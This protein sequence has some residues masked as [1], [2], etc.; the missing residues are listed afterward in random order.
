MRTTTAAQPGSL[1]YAEA[2]RREVQAFGTPDQIAPSCQQ[3]LTLR[4]IRRTTCTVAL[5]V[6]ILIAGWHLI[7]V[8][9]P[10][11]GYPCHRC[12]DS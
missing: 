8:A 1:S 3:E 4:Q 11:Q 2:A 6:P 9:G 12:A 5:A 7:W 10:G